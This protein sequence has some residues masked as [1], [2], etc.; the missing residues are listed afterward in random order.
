MAD[1]TMKGWRCDACSQKYNEC[2]AGYASRFTITIESHDPYHS[3]MSRKLDD[4]C[5]DCAEKIDK[6]L[7]GT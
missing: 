7:D 1:I 3:V 2:D 6:I 4:V 5:L